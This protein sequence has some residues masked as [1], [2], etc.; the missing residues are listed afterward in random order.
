VGGEADELK[1]TVGESAAERFVE[2][3]MKLGL[4]TGSTAVH[5]IRRLG[6]LL[7]AGKVSDIKGVATS[8]Q[9]VIEAQKAGIPLYALDDPI[10]DGALDLVIDGADE[11]D[12]A[13]NLTKG[14]GGALLI[15]KIVAYA[16]A[17]VVIV[18]DEKK[19]VDSLGLSFPIAVEVV[20][21]GRLTASRALERLGGRPELRMAARKM[22]AV[23]TDGGHM[24]LDVTFSGPIDPVAMEAEI[25][26]IPGVVENGLFTACNPHIL[27]IRE[28]G[29][30]FE[31]AST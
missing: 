22:G 6:R 4:G 31:M 9:S 24:I 14:G 28:S 8:S 7:A 11:V 19:I 1:Q 17:R 13:R 27:A 23:I 25:N 30:L 3:G 12:A 18:C 20:K 21:E 15:E 26:T 29:E 10:I 2:S 16:A 5:A